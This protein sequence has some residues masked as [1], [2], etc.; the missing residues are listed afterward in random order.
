MFDYI[1][2][3]HLTRTPNVPA[4]FVLH[5]LVSLARELNII[6]PIANLLKPEGF[7]STSAWSNTSV[8]VPDTTPIRCTYCTMSLEELGE[9]SK[10]MVCA[11]CRSKA[12][13]DV[14]YCSR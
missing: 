1:L 12:N 9:N 3:S 4:K 14:P 5:T 10:F 8:V 7:F 6:G 2:R 11:K 13:T